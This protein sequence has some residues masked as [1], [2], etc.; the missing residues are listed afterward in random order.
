MAVNMFKDIKL[1]N[2]FMICKNIMCAVDIHRQ[3]IKLVFSY[4]VLDCIDTL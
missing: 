1:E 4:P 3:A 2:N